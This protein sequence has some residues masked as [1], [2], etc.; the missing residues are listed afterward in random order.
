MVK[1]MAIANRIGS[2]IAPINSH[3][4]SVMAISQRRL[5]ICLALW[6]STNLRHDIRDG[7]SKSNHP[8]L[9]LEVH[10]FWFTSHVISEPEFTVNALALVQVASSFSHKIP[11]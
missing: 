7:R 6:G 5:M 2:E 9:Q 10:C 8:F 11:N 4:P 1:V 3:L